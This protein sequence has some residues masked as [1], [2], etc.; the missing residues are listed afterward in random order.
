MKQPHEY[1]RRILLT[2][3]GMSP[4]VVTETIYGLAHQEQPF[5]PTE[6][7][8][9][10]TSLGAEQARNT[11]L[12]ENTNWFQRLCQDYE[13]GD[14][15]FKSENIYVVPDH[16]G[17]ALA[18]I[19][20]QEDNSLAAD[21]ITNMVR[22]FTLDDDTAVHVS[23]AGGRKTMGFFLGYAL[24]LYGRAQDRLS[25]VLVSGNYESS[26]EF[27]YPSKEPETIE[28]K[29]G[30]NT[31]YLNRKDAVVTLADI[32]FVRMRV[33]MPSPLL[34][35]KA[36]YGE[37]VAALNIWYGPAHISIDRRN[38][39][40]KMAG[41]TFPLPPV[42]L[43]L[44]CTFAEHRLSGEKPLAAPNKYV[45]DRE[46]STRFLAEIDKN[47]QQ[48]DDHDGTHEAYKDGMSGSDLSPMKTKLHNSIKKALR[49]H[50]IPDYVINQYLIKG[51]GR[52]KHFS[53]F[54]EPE[55]IEFKDL[56]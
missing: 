41:Y 27:F 39:L 22:E 28:V 36:S 53:L 40:V 2:V 3:T 5:I 23:I 46:W 34:E 42:E 32:P 21:F 30:N 35:G 16:G 11:L 48:A 15:D 44:L 4:Q 9:I 25:H 54:V 13:L 14:I 18:D 12:A 20:S 43:A 8:L 49:A 26:K 55:N 56:T 45:P 6:V 17:V 31:L 51:R 33:G 52:P 50:L 47:S 38:H 7:H 19:R 1:K 10:S 37:S 24:S 29:V